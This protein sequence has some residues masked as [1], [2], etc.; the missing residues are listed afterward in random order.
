[1][2]TATNS[3]GMSSMASFTVT[4]TATSA[5]PAQQIETLLS[6]VRAANLPGGLTHQLTSLLEEALTDVQGGSPTFA[7]MLLASFI[8]DRAPRCENGGQHGGRGACP[9]LAEFIFVIEADQARR[10]AKIPAALASAWIAAARTIETELECNQ[11]T[12]E[13]FRNHHQD[14]S[15]RDR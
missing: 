1:M 7:R 4:V 14:D 2:C 8:R 3:Q 11:A 9:A 13:H 15:D 12:V 5:S 10:K 6:A